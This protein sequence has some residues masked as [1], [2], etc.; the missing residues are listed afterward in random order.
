MKSPINLI[1]ERT[2]IIQSGLLLKEYTSH[3]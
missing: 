1:K 2:K 3:K